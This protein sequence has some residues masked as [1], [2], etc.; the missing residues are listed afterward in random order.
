MP[1]PG[2]APH[3]AAPPSVAE[4]ERRVRGLHNVRARRGWK[5]AA[6]VSVESVTASAPDWPVTS[7]PIQ[8]SAVTPARYT[9]ASIV[10]STA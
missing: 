10:T 4:P 5:L 1:L 9:A 3:H 6:T 2:A 7:R 8:P